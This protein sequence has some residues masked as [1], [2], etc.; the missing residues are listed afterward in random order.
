M[1]GTS[2]GVSLS[3][4]YTFHFPTPHSKI[5]ILMGFSCCLVCSFPFVI[6]HTNWPSFAGNFQLD[7][8]NR[9]CQQFFV[10]CSPDNGYARMLNPYFKSSLRDRITLIKGPPF[11][12]ELLSIINTGSFRV[13]TFD[14]VFRHE[15]LITRRE[16][17]YVIANPMDRD[18]RASLAS[19]APQEILR[20]RKSQRI[21]R[22]L[23]WYSAQDY[24]AMKNRDGRRNLC[25]NYHLKGLCSSRSCGYEH[26][27]PLTAGQLVALRAVARGNP[28][29]PAGLNCDD[30]DCLNGQYVLLSCFTLCVQSD[31]S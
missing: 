31:G 24:Q 20:N 30:P 23:G 17:A 15:K 1:N 26:G 14:N 7:L 3:G 11:G 19:S 12:H 5:T 18:W 22:A 2:F 13:A 10:A 21:D 28:C 9:H 29:K 25:N 27:Q 8:H 6:Y 4:Y 16:A